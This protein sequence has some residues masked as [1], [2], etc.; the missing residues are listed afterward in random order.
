MDLSASLGGYRSPHCNVTD[1]ERTISTST[2]RWII[3]TD[4]KNTGPP[5][6]GIFHDIPTRL[7][8]NPLLAIMIKQYYCHDFAITTVLLDEDTI[9][10][11]SGDAL[12]S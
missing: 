3:H 12:S 10:Q 6:S 8:V 7:S 4:L 11:Q 2:V 1:R 9:K 5:P